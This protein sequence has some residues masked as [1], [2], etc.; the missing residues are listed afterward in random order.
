MQDKTEPEQ[1]NDE[2]EVEVNLDS[3]VVGFILAISLAW[4]IYS[5][6]LGFGRLSL[7]LL[8]ALVII[9]RVFGDV[10]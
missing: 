7:V 5:G 2:V 9:P 1:D 8:V 10:L 6:E 4:S 3:V